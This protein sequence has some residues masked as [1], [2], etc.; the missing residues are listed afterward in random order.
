MGSAG[1]WPWA[2]KDVVER[3]AIG[4]RAEEQAARGIFRRRLSR[5]RA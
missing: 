2:R 5:G 4:A 3:V 1:D